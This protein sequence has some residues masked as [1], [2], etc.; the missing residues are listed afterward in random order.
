[1]Q[2]QPDVVEHAASRQTVDAQQ[3]AA[4]NDLP[5]R[6]LVGEIAVGHQSDEVRRRHALE[7]ARRDV[8]AVAEDRDPV[9]IRKTSF[10]R[11]EM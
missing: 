9:P 7:H 6:V 5:A 10:I 8:P 11:C 1:M 2:G 4:A 3:L